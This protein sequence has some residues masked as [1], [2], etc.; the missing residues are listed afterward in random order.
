MR[1]PKSKPC[2]VSRLTAPCG[3]SLMGENRSPAHAGTHP[4]IPKEKR[5]PAQPA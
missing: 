1:Q 3:D 4:M 5:H 2:E